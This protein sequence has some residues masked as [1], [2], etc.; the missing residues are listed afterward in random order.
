MEDIY[1][2]AWNSVLKLKKKIILFRE[3][4]AQEKKLIIDKVREMFEGEGKDWY[5]FLKGGVR[6]K[7]KINENPFNPRKIDNRNKRKN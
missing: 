6:G 5:R 7:E 1:S 2:D 3:A 4:L